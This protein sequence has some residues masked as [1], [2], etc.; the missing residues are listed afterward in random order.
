MKS[1]VSPVRGTTNALSMEMVHMKLNPKL[2]PLFVI[3]PFVL[4]L[5]AARIS[6]YWHPKGGGAA[7]C[8]EGGHESH[9]AGHGRGHGGEHDC[10][11]T[12]EASPSEPGPGEE[13]FECPLEDICEFE[14]CDPTKCGIL[15]EPSDDTPGFDGSARQSEDGDETAK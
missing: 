13:G 5:G 1:A 8:N 4:L 15:D 3:V 7:G 9:D 14:E 12:A 10:E 6:G 2:F 11:A